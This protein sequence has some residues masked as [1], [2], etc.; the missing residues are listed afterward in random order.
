MSSPRTHFHWTKSCGESSRSQ[1]RTH[2]QILQGKQWVFLLCICVHL[3]CGGLVSLLC[4]CTCT[5]C[6]LVSL[7]GT[8]VSC[9]L[10]CSIY[11]KPCGAS[12]GAC[13]FAL[14]HCSSIG[15]QCLCYE[16]K[17]LQQK[18]ILIYIQA[19][20]ECERLP[21]LENIYA[22]YTID[23]KARFFRFNSLTKMVT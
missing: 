18:L 20:D 17:Q 3:S 15:M 19:P 12:G 13:M 14:Y 10:L 9:E 6:G 23:P 8:R 16:C 21:S 22:L 1:T 4:M 11:S 5:L 7:L 2:Q